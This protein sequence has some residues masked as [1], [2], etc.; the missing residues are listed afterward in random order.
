M[1]GSV[2]SLV[3]AAVRTVGSPHC[4]H[5]YNVSDDYNNDASQYPVLCAAITIETSI[6]D[7]P[8]RPA[9]LVLTANNQEIYNGTIGIELRGSTSQTLFP[10]K[11]YGVETW[12]ADLDDTDVELAGL[13]SEEDW[14]LHA[15]YAD[16]SLINNVLVYDL[17]RQMGRYAS[18]CRWVA[19]TLNNEFQGIYVL[20]EKLKRDKNRIDVKKNR[21]ADVSG[22][23]VLKID[24][25]TG[26]S[27]EWQFQT[28]SGVLVGYDYPKPEDVGEAQRAYIETYFADLEAA[29]GTKPPSYGNF[30]DVDSWV[31]YF[32]LIELTRNVDAYRLSAYFSKESGEKLKAG[33]V[34]DLNLGFGN[35]NFCDGAATAGWAFD[36]CNPHNRPIPWWWLVLAADQSFATA[37]GA[38]WAQLR[39]SSVFGLENINSLID[40]YVARLGSETIDANFEKWDILDSYVWSNPQPYRNQNHTM[41][42]NRR[43]SWIKNRIAWLDANM[44]NLP[45]VKPPEDAVEATTIAVAVGGTSFIL[46]AGLLLL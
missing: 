9:T 1:V 39:N 16:K 31:D 35:A 13:P 42:I 24:K 44:E 34:W 25:G 23:W 28:P 27:G 38:R 2:L 7:E 21:E 11:Q 40:G 14:I 41:Y 32:L 20:M 12:D 22:G 33:P 37:V 6:V 17:A 10:K 26:E 3:T 8:K 5:T 36:N 19:L 46:A 29:F 30:I 15:P 45:Y 43:K 4:P 18:R